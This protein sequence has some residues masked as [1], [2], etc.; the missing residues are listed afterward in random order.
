MTPKT[1]PFYP[2][3][4]AIF[5]AK[6][7]LLVPVAPLVLLWSGCSVDVSGLGPAPERP[8]HDVDPS[9]SHDS[10]DHPQGDG[11][12]ND[13]DDDGDLGDGDGNGNGKEG[14]G[15][16][17]QSPDSEP[18]VDEDLVAVFVT[19]GDGSE[20][21]HQRADLRFESQADIADLTIELDPSV[22][23]QAIDGFGAELTD[24][25]SYLFE[26]E[27][28][29]SERKSLI[30]RLFE[31]TGGIGLS[32]LR[33]PIGASSFSRTLYSYDDSPPDGKGFSIDHE[34]EYT[35]PLLREIRESSPDLLLFAAPY[36]APAWMKSNKSLRGGSLD[37]RYLGDFAEYLANFVSAYQ[38]EGL[39]VHAL[40]PQNEPYNSPGNADS[41]TMFMEASVEAEFVRDHL[42]PALDA[43]GLSTQIMAWDHNW[44]DGEQ[45]MDTV[46]ADASVRA[47]VAGTAF[48]CYLGDASAQS[49]VHE[50]YPDKEVWLTECWASGD[51]RDFE[52]LFTETM[53]LSVGALNNWSR[54][55]MRSSLALD[56]RHGPRVGGC[57]DCTGTLEISSSGDFALGGEY[58]ALGHFA[59][60]ATRAATRI[61]SRVSGDT[62]SLL[63]VAFKNPDH[64]RVLVL[65]NQSA[66]EKSV[67]L[68]EHGKALRVS[69]PAR[70]AMTLHW[71][72]T[73]GP[74]SLDGATLSASN[75]ELVSPPE[76]ALDGDPTTRWSS[77]RV[78]NGKLWLELDLGQ[79]K[80]FSALTLDS[81]DSTLDYPRGYE[82]LASNDAQTFF[83]LATGSGDAA[84]FTVH[85]PRTEARY[86]RI[87][88]TGESDD[89]WWSV[90][91]LALHQ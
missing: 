42:G 61:A 20:L 27:L 70:S 13:Q 63:S 56:E 35:L 41:P 30:R 81:G 17:D 51:F 43:R 82:I 57:T 26:T 88:C 55:F 45:Y 80:A 18:L 32:V 76:A 62:G 84:M 15:D 54:T 40:S 2:C 4:A 11:D 68:L 66:G 24:S 38:S 5:R 78:Q 8:A 75:S 16:G 86:V 50:L 28:D 87:A 60:F 44:D 64:S 10:D 83:T 33:Q 65:F 36:S 90:H 79:A 58:Y 1:S 71:A 12:L 67:R 47:R 91:E 73:N 48:H 34:R 37:T 21:L 85:F 59:K 69:V 19:R 52:G 31:S 6:H 49:R 7:V 23:Y 9:D 29:D 53:K 39:V 74:L 72:R 22:S 3:L 77:G 46:M 25:A 89:Y 14:D